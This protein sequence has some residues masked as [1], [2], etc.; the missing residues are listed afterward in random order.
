MHVCIC[1][2]VCMY[3][4]LYV[5]MY[6][7]MYVCMHVCMYACNNVR[8][9]VCVCV[10]VWCKSGEPALP[11]NAMSAAF[12][13]GAGLWYLQIG[14]QHCQVACRRCSCLVSFGVLG[15]CRS[16][17]FTVVSVDF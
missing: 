11:P 16:E 5:C 8:V 6:V 2:C 14:Q 15:A 4:C 1:V 13:S 12:V 7:S 17:G 3:V 9:C 10:F